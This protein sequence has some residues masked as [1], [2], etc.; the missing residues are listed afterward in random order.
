LIARDYGFRTLAVPHNIESLV[1]EQVETITRPRSGFR[2]LQNEIDQFK[3]DSASVCISREEQWLL[4]VSGVQAGFLP[5]FPIPDDELN[6]LRLRIQRKPAKPKKFLVLGSACNPPVRRGIMELVS[7]VGP[8]AVRR[9]YRIEVVGN[10]VNE[11]RLDSF[12]GAVVNRGRLSDTELAE[13]MSE[14][15]AAIV[16]QRQGCG[17]LTKI[18]ELLVAGIPVFGNA[19]AIRSTSQYEG[20]YEFDTI[21]ELESLMLDELPMPVPPSRPTVLEERFVKLLSSMGS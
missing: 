20:V 2:S 15:S 3:H 18:P 1:P 14:T 5:Y 4:N 21:D 7:I 16:F 12:G 13:I 8:I 10:Q 17:A 11:L 19:N 6:L 9:G